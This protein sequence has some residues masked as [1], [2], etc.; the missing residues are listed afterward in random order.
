MPGVALEAAFALDRPSVLSP[1]LALTVAH[2]WSGGL[3]EDGGIAT[4]TLGFVG[5]DA[6]PIRLALARLE[7]RVCAAGMLGRLAA[8][9]S[10]TFS[11]RAVARPFA[12][13][14]GSARLAVPLG[15]RVE[16]RARVGAGA[17]F[18]RDAFEF[19]PGV[20][21]RVASVTLVGDVGIAVRF[22]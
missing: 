19:S 4:F 2:V 9:G 12:T 5:L 10:Q 22:P 20:F 3:R 18:W 1:A 15:S 6:C 21:H 14:G 11:P 13:A 16:L 8:E 17:T 7:A